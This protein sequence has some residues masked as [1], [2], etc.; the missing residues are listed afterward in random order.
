MDILHH[1]ATLQGGKAMDLLHYIDLIQYTA[2]IL[3]STG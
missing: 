1:S 2:T 3:G